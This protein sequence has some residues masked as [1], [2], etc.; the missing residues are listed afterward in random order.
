MLTL[1]AAAG[2]NDWPQWLGPDRNGIS[3]ETGLLKQWPE[4]GPKLKWKIATLGDDG[5][6]SPVI[7]KGRIY[8]MAAQDD[9]EHL[10]ALEEKNGDKAWSVKI[11][12]IGPNKFQNYPGPRSTATV[13]GD[14]L[15][16][17]GSDG[18]LACVSLTKH[19]VVW[20]KN[21]AKDFDGQPGAWAYSES[22]LVDGDVVVVSPGGKTAT[23]VALNKKDGSVAWKC[24]L[25]DADQA[26]YASPITVEVGGVKQYVCYLLKGVV[27]VAAKDGTFLWRYEAPANPNPFLANIPTPLAY[28][29]M[30]F[31]TSGLGK[32]GGVV[33]LAADKGKVTATEVYLNE[34]LKGSIGGYV[35]VGEH[36]YGTSGSSPGGKAGAVMVCAEFATGKILWTDSAVGAAS[37]CVADGLL[38]VRGENG[39]VVLVEPTPKGY[40]EL[41]RFK[42][43]DRSKKPAWPYPVVAN[44]CL[45]LRDCGTLLC[46]DVHDPKAG[47]K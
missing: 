15:Y 23:I 2:A 8:L 22:P 9:A 32:G 35:R 33:K 42:Q 26:A 29:D 4:G 36:L 40:K 17:L 12:K 5:Y 18:D 44:G 37:F 39:V 21:L 14:K 20:T 41:G 47:K 13:D 24:A 28:K 43:T 31:A 19:D 25:P 10:V 3:T 30:V 27:G 34:D 7:Y 38:Y 45:Y 6:S 46:Y 1:T 11:G 16:V